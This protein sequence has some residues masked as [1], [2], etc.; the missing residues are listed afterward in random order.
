MKSELEE[1]LMRQLTGAGIGLP[2]RQFHFIA[3]LA[4]RFD[5]CWPNKQL[6]VEIHGGTWV[7]GGH[8]R[9][10]GQERDFERE[11]LAVLLGW[12]LL[13]FTTDQVTDG[14]ALAMIEAALGIRPTASLIDQRV[15]ETKHRRSQGARLGHEIRRQ[16]AAEKRR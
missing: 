4:Y 6:A 13:K 14:R 10:K 15:A 3:G 1:T 8:S 9:G 7:E 11:N 12:R 16:K 2:F 5:F